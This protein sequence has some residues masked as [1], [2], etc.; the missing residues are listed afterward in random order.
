MSRDDEH[1]EQ[2][3]LFRWVDVAKG[4]TPELGMLFAIPN[5]FGTRTARQGARAKAEGRRKGVPDLCLP[6]PKGRY[7]GLFI[8]MK[9][10]TNRATVEQR[11][12]L[13]ALQKLG[14]YANVCVGWETAREE[15]T[16]YLR[17]LL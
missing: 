8:E 5:W 17:G 16:A 15:I 2:A 12:W 10:G 7:H 11:A 13:D 6:V 1:L 4:Q 3:M 9:A 14:Y